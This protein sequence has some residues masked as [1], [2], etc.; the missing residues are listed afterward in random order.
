MAP[1]SS[2]GWRSPRRRSSCWWTS[3]PPTASCGGRA[4]Y[5]WAWY[6]AFAV[7]MTLVWLYLELL[8]LLSYVKWW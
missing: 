3:R 6:V 1:A 7:V 4:S 5:R 8:R 2:V